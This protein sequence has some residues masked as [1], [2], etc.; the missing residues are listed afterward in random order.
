VR[1]FVEED[2]PAAGIA[3]LALPGARDVD[4]LEV[5]HAPLA[6]DRECGSSGVD[7]QDPP[8]RP[9]RILRPGERGEHDRA[10]RDPRDVER[11]P[12]AGTETHG[13]IISNVTRN[14]IVEKLTAI[15]RHEKNIP[16][17]LLTLET[18]LADAGIDSLDSLTILFA[19][20]EQ[21]GISVPDDR[22]RA[23]TTFG[24]M[25]ALVEDLTS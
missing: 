7:R 22:A 1:D 23:M 18:P 17:D 19:I 6:R 25:V 9:R 5:V 12:A 3:A 13:C 21:F 20:E 14:E 8:F 15:V 2:D 4:D 24:D 10:E 16:D 11:P